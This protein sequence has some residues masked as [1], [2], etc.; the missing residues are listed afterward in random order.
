MRR[1]R[2]RLVLVASLA[3]GLGITPGAL[4]QTEVFEGPAFV[5]RFLS[6]KNTILN[7]SSVLWRR[8]S[9]LRCLEAC[10]SELTQFRMAGDWR[11]YL[12][13]LD[14]P[15]AKIACSRRSST[16]SSTT[17]VIPRRRP[18]DDS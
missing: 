9:L 15:G 5:R 4:S 10:R 18:N 1:S 13:C 8:T 12:E 11:L 17:A 6:V 2:P 14:A 7:V 16:R 3:I